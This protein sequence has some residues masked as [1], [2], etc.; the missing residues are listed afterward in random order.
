MSD[1]VKVLAATRELLVR[2]GS[3]RVMDERVADTFTAP[4]DE[5]ERFMY[6]SAFCCAYRQQ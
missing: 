4:G 6:G 1:P 3:L 5:I 2:R